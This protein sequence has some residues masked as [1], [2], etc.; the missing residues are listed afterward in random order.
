M[1][2]CKTL[3]SFLCSKDLLRIT[4]GMGKMHNYCG[5]KTGQNLHVTGDRVRL[6]FYSNGNIERGGYLLCFT[7]VSLSSF[8]SGKWDYKEVDK[9]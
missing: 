8:S 9:P 3:F 1:V 2:C 6:A 7:L 4:D 5:N